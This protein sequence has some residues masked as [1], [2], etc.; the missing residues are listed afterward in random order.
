M[1]FKDVADLM[2]SLS[3]LS[4]RDAHNPN[5]DIEIVCTSLLPGEKLYEELLIDADSEPTSPPPIYRA[6]ENAILPELLRSQI[7][8]LEAAIQQQDVV[9]ALKVLAE[10][11]PESRV[12]S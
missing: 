5:G 9:A 4:L 7:D 6:L 12:V 2:V 10:L 3:G 8:A 1:R 11:V